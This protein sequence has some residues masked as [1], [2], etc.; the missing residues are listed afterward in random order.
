VS[1]HAAQPAVGPGSVAWR[2]ASDARVALGAGPA[3]VLQVAH[4]VVAAGVREFSDFERDPWGRL[5]RTLDY[6]TLLVYGGPEAAARTARVTREMHRPIRG[7]TPDGRPYSALEPRAYAWVHATLVEMVVA[8]HA[9]FARP[10]PAV[11]VERLYAEWLSLGALLGVRERD[12]PP[13][14]AGF[15]AYVD[16]TVRDELADSDVVQTVLRTLGR[17]A[18]PPV[19]LVPGA[20]WSVALRGP[21]A[22]AGLATRALLPPVLRARLGLAWTPGHEVAL[23][24]LRLATRFGTPPPLRCTGPFYLR[25][26]RGA[27]ARGPYGP[28]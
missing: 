6:A 18:A 23:R 24:A 16:A 15:R 3:L 5:L 9:V 22:V 11:E 21:S 7:V 10:L 14:W 12:L 19:A 25:L 28:G 20:A 2:R 17:P 4:P 27:I 13:T 26:R 1:S 8:A